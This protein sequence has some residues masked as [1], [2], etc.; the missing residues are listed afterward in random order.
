MSSISKN[1]L[2]WRDTQGKELPQKVEELSQW[3]LPGVTSISP[4]IAIALA[5]VESQSEYFN[6]QVGLLDEFLQPT[7]WEGS[8]NT[9]V[10]QF[11]ETIAF[12][13]Q[14]L[15]G[16]VAMQTQQAE[17]VKRLAWVEIP[18]FPA[19]SR[20]NPSRPFYQGHWVA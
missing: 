2:S 3:A 1:L 16:A 20:I 17:I 10:T 9:I 6:N 14:A 7:G 8:G 5:G 11:P 12:V 15:L 4:L 18:D 13:Y 19:D